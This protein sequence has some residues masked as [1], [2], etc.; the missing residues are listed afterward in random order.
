MMRPNQTSSVLV[1]VPALLLAFAVLG[2]G[3]CNFNHEWQ[4]AMANPAPNVDMQG[5]WQGRWNSDANGHN[6]KLRCVVTKTNEETYLARFHANYGKIFTFGYIIP[7]KVERTPDSFHF[8]GEANLGYFAGGVYQ[9]DGHAEA[10][11]F[12]S[13]YSNKYDH[14]T[15]QM[16]RP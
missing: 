9:Y 15:F 6:G 8:S 5:P 3:C 14:G 7:L 10:T 2:V 11:N 13:T 1:F 16:R 4:K 12:F